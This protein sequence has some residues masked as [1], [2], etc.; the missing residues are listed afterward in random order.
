MSTEGT[1]IKE[2]EGSASD[3]SEKDLERA[4]KKGLSAP[5][6]RVL[7]RLLLSVLVISSITVFVT[8]LMKYDELQREKEVLRKEKEALELE[9]EELQYLLDCPVDYD[10]IIR[11][12]RE[13]LGL[14]LPDE[15]IYYTDQN[16]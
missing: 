13:K 12:A 3:V 1:D 8:G 2:T 5:F 4:V 11:V 10:Y 6:S 9:I 14:H 15:I 16:K 7:L